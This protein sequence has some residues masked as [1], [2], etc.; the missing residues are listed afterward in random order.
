MGLTSFV[1]MAR[2]LLEG[3]GKNLSS[4]A[5]QFPELVCSHY[6]QPLSISKPGMAG[7]VF[8]TCITPNLLSYSCFTHRIPC[9]CIVAT[10]KIHDTC[11]FPDQLV[12]SL[13][14][15]CNFYSFLAYTIHIHR[16][17]DVDAVISGGHYS[18]RFIH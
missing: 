6:C 3:L 15:I 5:L 18:H 14:S 17:W 10:Q 16:S 1:S 7:L 8:L 4:C 13:N 11:S 9:D 2:F 12:S